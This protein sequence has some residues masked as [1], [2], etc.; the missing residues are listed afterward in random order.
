MKTK[1][2]L[3]KSR[4]DKDVKDSLP[5]SQKDKGKKRSQ[6]KVFLANDSGERP[7]GM[8]LLQNELP[9]SLLLQ[10]LRKFIQDELEDLPETWC[11][12]SVSEEGLLFQVTARQ[13]SKFY[14]LS[15]S[16]K[17][18][19]G[20]F[21]VSI[22]PTMSSYDSC[23]PPYVEEDH[24]FRFSTVSESKSDVCFALCLQPTLSSSALSPPPY[25]E[26]DELDYIESKLE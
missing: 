3:Y 16:R 17:E 25:V 15:V 10:D 22:G 26:E 18:S 23:P 1:D 9:A 4:A 24:E 7:L 12:V 13:E 20:S 2:V 14:L 11:F 6:V 21:A 8:L 19:D 5:A